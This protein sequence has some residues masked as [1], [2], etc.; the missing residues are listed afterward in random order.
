MNTTTSSTTI[1]YTPPARV[2]ELA[3]AFV[4][5]LYNVADNSRNLYRRTLRIYFNWLQSRGYHLADVHAGHIAEY[6]DSL[7]SS[8]HSVLSVASYLNTVK[9]FYKFT[10]A[11]QLYRNVAKGVKAPSPGNDIKKLPLNHT[12]ASAL[13]DYVQLR[14][15]RDY[16][17]IT[18]LVRTG[19][20]TVEAVRADVGDIKMR[21]GK[22][23]L[24]VHGK[25]RA[26][27]SDFVVLTDKAYKP[28]AEYLA[29]RGAVRA[30]E[31]LF[32]STSNNNR[33]GRLTTRTVSQLAKDYL[34][35]IGLDEGYFTAHSLR[36]TAV[37]SC[38]RAGGTQE[39][40]QAMARHKSPITTQRYD[41]YFREEARIT[42][43]GEALI[44]NMF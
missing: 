9:A 8:G 39:Q 15:A 30:D 20:R 27:K 6:R 7:V 4:S 16:A 40:A 31:P 35:A 38:R 3:D 25:G 17:I 26:D 37:V 23:V 18:L 24:H 29:S 33:G 28:I 12:Q 19:L 5:N 13:L 32:T 14:S 21:Q 41:R 43:S 1:T 22:R 2:D 10:E 44:D 11:H 36:Y 42:H 34:R